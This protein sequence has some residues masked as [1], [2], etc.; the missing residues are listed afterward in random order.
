MKNKT[1]FT[2]CLAAYITI[3]IF[4]FPDVSASA[5]ALS[6]KPWQD[7][8][9]ESASV[10][11]HVLA[12][13]DKTGDF[14]AVNAM[15]ISGDVQTVFLGGHANDALNKP[16][17]DVIGFEIENWDLETNAHITFLKSKSGPVG[18]TINGQHYFD[19]KGSSLVVSSAFLGEG[20]NTVL[21][22]SSN[23]QPIAIENIRFATTNLSADG[24]SVLQ[25][26]SPEDFTLIQL[27]ENGPA[28]IDNN[29]LVGFA[30]KNYQ[31][32]AVPLSLSN[33]TRG[34]TAYRNNQQG[35]IISVK[36]GVNRDMSESQLREAQVMFFDYDTKSWQQAFVKNVDHATFMIEADVPG[37][38]DYFAAM[39]KSPEMPEASAFMPTAISDLE[40]KTPAEG[41]N[42]IQPPSANQQGDAN[43]SYPLS[44]PPG[45]QGMAPQ[46]ALS[47][48]SSGGESWCGYGW[49][50]ATQSI[51]VDTR[52]GVPTFDNEFESEVYSLNGESLHGQDGEKAN[53]PKVNG[54][55]VEYASRQ[56]GP[57]NFFSR[58][59]GG[60]RTIVRH[61]STPRTYFWVVTDASQTKY[62]YGTKDGLNPDSQSQLKAGT[63]ITQWYLSRVED[64]WG[65]VIDYTYQTDNSNYT[66][67]RTG[68]MAMWLSQITYTG[69][70][71]SKG[72]TPGKYSVE[73]I[74][75]KGRL[76]TRI[77]LNKG[78]KLIDD[79]KLTDVV[80]KYDGNEVKRYKLDLQNGYF[81]KT[82]LSG[83][84]EWHQNGSTSE[85]FYEHTFDYFG[86]DELT[87]TEKTI[88]IDHRNA[89][90]G[91]VPEEMDSWVGRAIRA[92]VPPSVVSSSSSAGWTGGARIGVGYD[93]LKSAVPVLPQ[94]DNVKTVGLK[95][96]RGGN[97]TIT[98]HQLMDINGDG[99]PDILMEFATGTKMYRPGILA[100]SQE[101]SFG[102]FTP[103]EYRKSF[104]SQSSSNQLA[105][106]WSGKGYYAGLSWSNSHSAADRALVDYNSDGVLD[107]LEQGSENV[108]ILFGSLA[109]DGSLSFENNS[110]NSL[111]PVIK[112][113]A[114]SS[115][116]STVNNE[117][118]EIVRFWKAPKGGTVSIA[119]TA[120]CASG[121]NGAVKVAIQKNGA[122]IYPFTDV[123][124]NN[125][126]YINEQ[127]VIVSKG[128]I[129]MFRTHYNID[130]Y[131][132]FLDWDPQILYSNGSDITDGAG[133][134]Y[135]NS[136]YSSGFLVSS[137]SNVIVEAEDVIKI[138]LGAP[139]SFTAKSDIHFVIRQT[140]IDNSTGDIIDEKR[141]VSVLNEGVSILPTTF[142][143][144]NGNI[145]PFINQTGTIDYSDPNSKILFGFEMLSSSNIN[146]QAPDWRPTLSSAPA[147]CPNATISQLPIVHKKTYNRLVANQG[148]QSYTG[149]NGTLE[150]FVNINVDQGD[151][152]DL[153]QDFDY[154]DE[155]I[156]YMTT[157][158][159]SKT[160]AEKAIVI[161]K[162]LG[163]H[164]IS[165]KT[166]G[167][168]LVPETSLS[169]T[170][171]NSNSAT[172]F[173][174]GELVPY[175]NK[176][177]HFEF[178][179]SD[180]KAKEIAEYIQN[181]LSSIVVRSSN[182]V[183]QATYSGSALKRNIFYTS[184]YTDQFM[185]FKHWGQFAWKAHA[186]EEFNPINPAD[187]HSNINAMSTT[188]MNSFSADQESIQGL[189]LQLDA[190]NNRYFLLNPTRGERSTA[191]RA[192]HKDILSDSE[193]RDRWSYAN[194]HIATYQDGLV[195]P[196]ILGES[197]NQPVINSFSSVYDAYGSLNENISNSLSFQGGAGKKNITA[198]LQDG[199][200]F[201]SYSPRMFMDLNGDR[202]P[203][204]IKANYAQDIEVQLTNPT[205]GHGT[206]NTLHGIGNLSKSQNLASGITYN[207]DYS[208]KKPKFTLETFGGDLGYSFS[209]YSL[210]DINGDGLQDRIGFGSSSTLELNNGSGFENGVTA[211]M[212][213]APNNG[214]LDKNLN[215]DFGANLSAGPIGLNAEKD[216]LDMSYKYES[217]N[218][219]TKAGIGV[220]YS[221]QSP[222]R[223]TVDLNGDGLVDII[224]IDDLAAFHAYKVYLNTGTSFI[225]LSSH[226]LGTTTNSFSPIS[227]SNTL[228]AYAN[229]TFTF[230][231]K[232]FGFK[233]CLGPEASG[234]YGYT[235]I[236]SS[237]RDM[238][239]D[240]AVDIAYMTNTGDLKVYYSNQALA[241]KLKTVHN[242]L[243]GSFDIEYDFIAGRKE[244]TTNP[245]VKTDK[246][247][248][249]VVWHMNSGRYVLGK[250]TI[251]DGVDISH[252]GVDIDGSDEVIYTYKYDG[253]VYN[254]REREFHGFS[255]VETIHQDQLPGSIEQRFVSEVTEY[256]GLENISLT[257]FIRHSAIS[258]LVKSKSTYL[259][260]IIPDI[261]EPNK[262]LLSI[263]RYF[264]EHF[265]V[266]QF[267]DQTPINYQIDLSDPIHTWDINTEAQSVFNA[268]TGIESIS[269]PN[270]NERE[271]YHA[272]KIDLEYDVYGNVVVFKDYGPIQPQPLTPTLVETKTITSV[273]HYPQVSDCYGPYFSQIS[274][275]DYPN[276]DIY[277]ITCEDNTFENDTII[278]PKSD[279]AGCVG[280]SYHEVCVDGGEIHSVHRKVV[281][282]VVEIYEDRLPG[283]IYNGAR[284]AL[285]D[286]FNPAQASGQ[287]GIL[288]KQRVYV[289]NT[290]PS[291]LRRQ[292]E[293]TS[294]AVNKAPSE[295]EVTLNSTE[296]AVSNIEYD[297]YG[298][299]TTLIGAENSQSQRAFSQY[300]YD[301]TNHQFVEGITNHFSESVCNVFD[302][303]TGNILRST[304][305]NNHAIQY[306]YDEF[307]RVKEIWAPKELAD[308]TR[309]PTV[310]YSY[311]LSTT[312]PSVAVSYHNTSASNA[313]VSYSGQGCG[314]N[315]SLPTNQP[316][317]SQI[318]TATFVDGLGQ[319]IQVK[320]DRSV[321]SGANS[322]ANTIHVSGITAKNQFGTTVVSRADFN[323]PYTSITAL[324]ID[325]S[326]VIARTEMFDYMY[327]PTETQQ[328]VESDGSNYGF[329]VT[330]NSYEWDGTNNMFYTEQWVNAIGNSAVGNGVDM[331][332]R[333]YV[334]TYGRKTLTKQAS[335]STMNGS[336]N[337]TFTFSPLSE[338]LTVTDPLGEVTTYTYDL[339]GRQLSENHPDRG[340]TETNYDKASNVISITNEATRSKS[341]SISLSYDFNRL[342][343]KT[344]AGS[345]GNDL[346]DI[347]YIYGTT[348]SGNA[349]NGIGR[350]ITI[351]QGDDGNG[352][353]FK[354]DSFKYDELGNVSEEAKSFDVPN[355]G[356]RSYTTSKLYD[357]FG[358][359]RQ[360]SYPDGDIVNYSY[361]GFGELYSISST[362]SGFVAQSIISNVQ[363]DGYGNIE[364]LVYGNGA[365][366]QYSYSSATKS[367]L[368]SEVNAKVAG[369]AGNVSLMDRNYTYNANGMIATISR[370]M[371][372]SLMPQGEHLQNS[373]FQYDHLGRLTTGSISISGMDGSDQYDVSTSY[374]LAGG[375]VSK[376][377]DPDATA[378]VFSGTYSEMNYDLSYQYNNTKP[379]Q[380]TEV[381]SNVGVPY[382]VQFTYNSSGSI[383]E[384]TDLA[385]TNSSQFYWN[386]E[387]W[388]S[389]VQ[390]NQGIH[391]YV[392]DHAGERVMKSSITQT[393]VQLNDE[394]IN[395][396]T[397]LE[398]Y[399]LYVNPYYVVTAF[400]NADKKS[401][402]YYMG[403]QRVA[404]DIGISYAE[405]PS[406]ST[407]SN[408]LK[409]GSSSIISIDEE[410]SE[411]ESSGIHNGLLLNITYI[412]SYFG[413]SI[414]NESFNTLV[415][416][417]RFYPD[418]APNTVS[419]ATSESSSEPLFQGTRILYWYHPD[420]VSNVDL[421]TDVNGEAFEL[422]L[423]NAWGESLHHWTSNSSNS[424]SSPYRFNSKELDPETGMHYYGARYHHPKL[425]IWMSVDPDSYK[426]PTSTPFAYTGNNPIIAIDPDGR[427]A[428]VIV[429]PDYKISVGKMQ[430]PGLGHAGSLIIDPS[431]GDAYYVEYGRYDSNQGNARVIGSSHKVGKVTY[432]KDGKPTDE[433]LAVVLGKISEKAGKGGR[434][435]AAEF[436]TT[437]DEFNNALQAQKD[438]LD[439]ASDPDREPYVLSGENARNCGTEACDIVSENVEEAEIPDN[440][441]PRPVK[442]IQQILKKSNGTRIEYDP[443][444]N[445]VTRG[446]EYIQS[447]E[448]QMIDEE[449]Q[450]RN[451]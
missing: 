307:N 218:G 295:L 388:L 157:K 167:D 319:A 286:Y 2:E 63:N 395:T 51:S 59:Q 340:L 387:Q 39:I 367:L 60:Y 448:E 390:N 127:N 135:F 304:G 34:A 109:E 215:V 438:L 200:V 21:F 57:Q 160:L 238:N 223:L 282:E 100:G 447:G 13:N 328:L 355:V 106:D 96:V 235:R 306:V 341:G 58:V 130:G 290:T 369:T 381:S 262:T 65:N 415:P 261:E 406:L 103:I 12:T 126:A 338:L 210:A 119:C 380:L 204:V 175:S 148:N 244:V 105:L 154:G 111:N 186:G 98:K 283:N 94:F 284:I 248:D 379:H 302:Y 207:A 326:R 38:T 251:K 222:E 231:A 219:S 417:E 320:T 356:T 439:E 102:P 216:V 392:Y 203:D 120:S 324:S 3:F 233:F 421:V 5:H 412:M 336:S 85:K 318:R 83:V 87:Y 44:L 429:F 61:G 344:M 368:Q 305:V 333:E 86:S 446:G 72:Y 272:Q 264:Y 69:F 24:V 22:S 444:T 435:E 67:I 140:E 267:G 226:Q 389:G 89:D 241:N 108:K 199:T 10:Y 192:Y 402:H 55:S 371:H 365:E 383:S 80:I 366:T 14:H 410:L 348:A 373:S 54:N 173:N 112:N 258:G 158:G 317:A 166:V 15:S 174:S 314:L 213:A 202:Y 343:S 296:V 29:N 163:G 325:T 345:L 441:S 117:P 70:K 159:H 193:D 107:I 403:T 170:N 209:D 73:F 292:S 81:N 253:G 189:A 400:S 260:E 33:V 277:V 131:E 136:T 71:G 32:A 27:N 321:S 394:T 297:Q 445:T 36:I 115:S 266:N 212:G 273:L 274:N 335:N 78:L 137:P 145:A 88:S 79:R 230:G 191:L 144:E 228:G 401:K 423:Y 128:D 434:I 413:Q 227:S 141:Y 386:D 19:V 237:F 1:S 7:F 430:V 232:I 301:A 147:D 234:N 405:D 31:T 239:G 354:V 181:H 450:K 188:D 62:F 347:D 6:K 384:I 351:K 217:K 66:G 330:N 270:K 164:E 74:T 129:I 198:N 153:L 171:F 50:I 263:E 382:H 142:V 75:S 443:N 93:V 376:T 225:Q 409:L 49:N 247:D 428:Y 190:Q 165:Y 95:Y 149:S 426:F 276:H 418:L 28:E 9:Y 172:S 280:S 182:N 422:F 245:V 68:G 377:S 161:T 416:I 17:D 303:G 211:P 42:L 363:Y 257:S 331:Y 419:N 64:K 289:N 411:P 26:A 214:L 249:V 104:A 224:E 329:T 143:D 269:F 327:R 52:W 268:V 133:N 242:P 407:E 184:E 437:Q 424:W 432:G 240:G 250:V 118:I 279:Q 398:P 425:S 156:A 408:N 299:I 113:V 23:G 185:P 370:N 350:I 20:H 101:L 385:G 168:A 208:N 393:S 48:S 397:T 293:V 45:R 90:A 449:I 162:K 414:E 337:T 362:V 134:A 291:N 358:R 427:E 110:G 246:Q 310:R 201:F 138:D 25:S 152:N 236:R 8:S 196:G 205:G 442:M 254:P 346:Y 46:L 124:S 342:I 357:S 11:S 255:R 359:I 37:G 315:N 431:T 150:A 77:S 323:D 294:L 352:N 139:T 41:I 396:I 399:T 265:N 16:T 433:S 177:V 122:F 47:Y 298:N 278:V 180:Q 404:T 309:G 194:S 121:S 288:R 440:I 256:F 97:T 155:L 178:S 374:N 206:E 300:T 56:A 183:V 221:G 287:T 76:D 243:G 308:I 84:S 259:N 91:D 372:T 375:I 30:L 271:L 316:M 18:V 187:M 40:P 146:W 339:A 197:T 132:D 53:R 285:L 252:G 311:I 281:S 176:K 361:T 195:S 364:K 220:N 151:L 436:A 378:Q 332:S 312:T 114:V 229:G 275:T 313:G 420:Y 322:N 360:A 82:K 179:T 116:P 4:L 123:S 92:T 99:I 43:V 451:I 353:H 125:P 35:Q 334:D 391:H 169:S 349:N